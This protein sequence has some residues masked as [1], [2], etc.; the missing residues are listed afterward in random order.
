MPKEVAEDVLQ[1]LSNRFEGST[2]SD[3]LNSQIYTKYGL[4]P[5]EL[6]SS[7][8]RSHSCALEPEEES[9]SEARFS[10]EE[11]ESPKAKAEPH[12]AEAEPAKGKTEPPMAQSDSQLF[13]QLLV[14][15]GMALPPE[16]KEAA[17]GELG[18]GRGGQRSWKKS[19]IDPREMGSQG[20]GKAVE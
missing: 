19:W 7:L 8:S 9:K 12:K 15:E 17:S 11:T 13:N 1:V 10:E 18:A 6:S 5:D 2:L 20:R 4:R 16:I 3:L 14:T